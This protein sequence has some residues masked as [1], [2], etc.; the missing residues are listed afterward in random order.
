MKIILASKSP[1]RKELLG[2]IGISFEIIESDCDENITVTD[3][4]E[5]VKQLSNIKATAVYDKVL[6]SY[7]DDFLVVGADTIVFCNGQIMGKP[8]DKEDAVRMLKMLKAN[9]HSVYTGVALLYI[10]DGKTGLINFAEETKVTFYDMTDEEIIRYVESG[11]PMDKA[12]AYAIQGLCAAYIKGIE[13][14]YPNVVG[15]P[16]SRIVYELKKEKLEV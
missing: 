9:T 16:V 14:D 1:R 13:G 2:Q 11:E 3:P 8:K 10:K 12:G 5:M 4:E 7:K 15:L 6:V